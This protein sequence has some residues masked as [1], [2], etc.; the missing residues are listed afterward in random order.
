MGLTFLEILRGCLGV[1]Y[2]SVEI[3]YVGGDM[4][5]KIICNVVREFLRLLSIRGFSGQRFLIVMSI[6]SLQIQFE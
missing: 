5:L 4:R 2:R 6:F 3:V 1:G